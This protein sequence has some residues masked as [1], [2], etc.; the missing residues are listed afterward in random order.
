MRTALF[1]GTFDPFTLGHASIVDR[2]LNLFDNIVVAVGV[3]AEKTALF[4]LQ[5][6]LDLIKA[7]YEH[8][9]RVSVCAYEGLTVTIAKE[10]GACAILRGVRSIADYEYERQLSDINYRLS[11][12]ETVCLF[13]EPN[14]AF[15]Q[16][17]FVRDLLRHHQDVSPYVP[18]AICKRIQP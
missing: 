16:S 18:Q 14:L 1:P 12:I 11:G 7:C 4:S 9:P 3:N 15:V 13:T 2:G 5:D 10:V 17:S 8:E 6:R